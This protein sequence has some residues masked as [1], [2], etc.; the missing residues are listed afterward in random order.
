MINDVVPDYGHLRN[1]SP[2]TAQ[3]KSSRVSATVESHI[4]PGVN[5]TR[6]DFLVRVDYEGPQSKV[7]YNFLGKPLDPKPL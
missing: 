6:M 4:N 7:I 1:L 2:L 5:L 3:Q